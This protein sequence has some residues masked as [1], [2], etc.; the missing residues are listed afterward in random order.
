MRN[1]RLTERFPFL[2]PL[3]VFQRR[4]FFY[5]RMRLDGRRYCRAHSAQDLPHLVYASASPLYNTETGFPMLYQENKVH[6]LRLAAQKLDGLL[7][8]PGDTFSFFRS[9]RGAD[10]TEPYK[11][12]LTVLNGKLVPA[13]GGGMCQMSNLLYWLFLHAPLRVVERHGHRVKDFPDPPS[14]A[15]HGVDATLHEGWLDLKVQN[16][17]ETTYEIRLDF[18]GDQLIGRLLSDRDD[19]LALEV[20]NGEIAYVRR[21]G[22]IYEEADVLRRVLD[23]R[24]GACLREEKLYRNVCRV[25]YA[26]APDTPVREADGEGEGG[27]EPCLN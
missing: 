25:G 10:R 27:N 19:G 6:N 12:G 23:R 11:D 8:R 7:L 3:R 24:T 17:T 9:I 14:D 22:E 20:R 16:P 18:A 2:L 21:K 13:P 4:L 26:L 5:L 15:P 1:F